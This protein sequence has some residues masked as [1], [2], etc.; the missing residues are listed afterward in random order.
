MLRA[1]LRWLAKLNYK[2]VMTVFPIYIPTP[3]VIQLY[4]NTLVK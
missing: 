1:T 2:Q 3:L 4:L